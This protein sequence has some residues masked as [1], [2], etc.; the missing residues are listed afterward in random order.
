MR[1]YHVVLTT[2]LVFPWS[3]LAL[4][5]FGSMWNRRA[6]QA[7]ATGVLPWKLRMSR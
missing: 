4:T 2:I 7:E 3:L 1:L 6:R 5:L